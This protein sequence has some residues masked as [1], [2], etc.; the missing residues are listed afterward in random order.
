MQVTNN[1]EGAEELL[2]RADE[3]DDPTNQS[4][5]NREGSR[6]LLMGRGDLSNYAR[7][8]VRAPFMCSP[9]T[10]RNYPLPGAHGTCLC[11]RCA[12]VTMMTA[13]GRCRRASS[14]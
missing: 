11:L 7:E 2:K 8:S 3:I 5:N 4:L 13:L 9:A 1:T 10:C 12:V 14:R 6:L